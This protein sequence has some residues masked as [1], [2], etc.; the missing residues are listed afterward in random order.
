[1][2]RLMMIVAVAG[3]M[4][5]GA[6]PAQAETFY[7]NPGESIQAAINAAADYDTI[8]ISEGTYYHT[9]G[10]TISKS[11]TIQGASGA[12]QPTLEFSDGAYDGVRVT[13]DDVTVDN[14]RIYRDGHSSYNSLL[15]VPKG[16]GYPN[17][18]VEH[19]HE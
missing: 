11:L 3:L 14:L 7:V 10:L 1:M 17:Y 9:S 5:A 19:A 6:V 12:S 16:G 18:T 8:I 13:A 15:S 4:A 2:K